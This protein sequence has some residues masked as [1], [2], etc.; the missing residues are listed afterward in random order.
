MNI[1][2]S[3][4]EEVSSLLPA[5]NSIYEELIKSEVHSRW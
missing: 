1:Q 4:L 5:I 2:A 3:D